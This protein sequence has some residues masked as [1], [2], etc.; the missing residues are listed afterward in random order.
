MKHC[1]EQVSNALLI[2]FASPLGLLL[3]LHRIQRLQG[4]LEYEDHGATFQGHR[5][6]V[7]KWAIKMSWAASSKLHLE[8][9]L[10][11]PNAP[12]IQKVAVLCPLSS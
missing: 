4:H 5:T 10:D 9:L 2:A 1:S 3:V 6:Y 12:L 11:V 7:V 8:S